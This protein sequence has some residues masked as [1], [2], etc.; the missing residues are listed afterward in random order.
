M[1]INEKIRI[2][3]ILRGISLAKLSMKGAG[4]AAHQTAQQ[5]ENGKTRPDLANLGAVADCLGTTVDYL[6]RDDDAPLPV[7][8][9]RQ[10]KGVEAKNPN[11]I[12]AEWSPETG[13]KNLMPMA[14][15]LRGWKELAADEQAAVQAIVD[16][17]LSG[18]VA[19]PNT[20]PR[21]RKQT[22]RPFLD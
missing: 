6:V 4:S 9:E 3:R 8:D 1:K 21:Q 19:L 18:V 2:L 22:E 17:V 13:A 12:S 15:P 16:A 20:K 11:L 10:H 5:W 14:V 7:I